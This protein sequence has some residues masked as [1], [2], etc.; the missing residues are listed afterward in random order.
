MQLKGLVRFFAIAL[1][2]ISFYQLH[3]TLVVRNH[4]KKQQEK[5]QAFVNANFSKAET[6]IKDLEFNKR[7]RR[8]LDST[9]E[10]TVTYGITGAITYQKAKEQELNLGLDLQGGM[11]V[12]LEVELEG[13]IKTLANNPK[14][15]SLNNAINAAILEK[16]NSD[17]DFITLFAN[18]Y[19]AQ[20]PNGK[21]ASLFAGTGGRT[22]KI[23]DTDNDVITKLKAS[24]EG[25]ISN[26]FNVLGKRI[27]QFGVAQPNIQL[28]K[29]KGII[30]VELPGVKDDPERVRKYLQATANLQFWE[31]YN[32]GELDKP[33]TDAEKALQAYYATNKVVDTVAAPV[34]AT[35]GTT[36]T[37]KS[38]TIGELVKGGTTAKKDSVTTAAGAQS[39]FKIFQ[40]VPP[41][42]DAQGR[43]SFAPYIGFI[44]GRDTSVFNEYMNLESVKSQ[45]PGNVRFAFG[46]PETNENGV[47]SDVVSIYALK[48]V[49]GS[50][51]AKLE[52]DGVQQ[53]TQDYDDKGRPAIKM[54][55]TKQGERIWGEL[56][57]N[58][59]GKPIAIVLDNIVYSAPNVINPITT[60]NSEISGSFTIEEAQDLSN[61]LQSGKLPAPAKIV[62]EQVVGPTLGASA[63][64]GGALAFAISFGVIFILMLV[65]YNTGGWVANIALILNLLFTIGVLSALGATLTAPGIAGLVLTI[66]MAVDTNVI[67][68][69]RIKE[70]LT[71]GKSY[72]MA[73]SEGYKRSMAPVLDAHITTLLTALILF[74]FGLGP[75]L[76]FA[77]T[78]ILGIILSLFCG[79][80]ISRLITDF[81]TNKKR[82]FNY[83]TATSK[84]VFKHASYKFIEYRKVAY[85]ISVIVLIVG[86]GALFNGFD[87]GVEY[88][89]G[90]SYT[91]KFDK[92]TENEK[93][94]E[95]LKVVFEESPVLKT[96]GDNKTL[97]ITTS[98]MI[99]NVSKSADSVVENK[100]FE[101]LKSSLPAGITY[102]EFKKNYKQSSQ[103]V[104]PSISDDLKKGAVQAT[105]FAILAIILYIFL[106]F[107]DWRY[108][109]G[110]IIALLHDVFVTLAVFSF[111][112]GVVPFPLEIDQHF[113]AAILTVI[114]FSMNDTVIVFDRIREYSS[115]LKGESKSTIIN[116][117]INDTLSRTIMTSLTVFL[118]LLILFIFGGEVTRGFA[119]AMLIGVVTGTYSSIFVAAPVLVDIAKDK[120]LGAA[121]AAGSKKKK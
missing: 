2:L 60:G 21:L 57:T 68:F 3:F 104:Q 26:T 53:A 80:L 108:S 46:I 119:F 5:A 12:T 91:V 121:D 1:I 86:V 115:K 36:D 38:A 82:H 112:K 95:S 40:P 72:Q 13:L 8:L 90:R 78:Q 92:P 120:P 71:L 73:V 35:A 102:A 111:L 109:L 7:L 43:M 74:Y 15:Q 18:A 85:F 39:F 4:E 118:T 30:T 83:F 14:D 99:D 67:I 55:M 77:T 48:T 76:G 41:Q 20:N 44:S 61:I 42:Q 17:A 94:R 98:F 64:E 88:K 117:A 79:I 101:G 81:W 29:T 31:L 100:L 93:I 34:A 11:S 97:N 66:G 37:T 113:I 52:G 87:Q 110:T 106:R 32:I 27:D 65:Y 10:T 28:D 116:R 47:K 96:V 16:S 59:V 50:D 49:E 51:R 24:A 62:Q 58:N 22:V 23:E 56:T 105:I 45:F 89:G 84:R 70:E 33:F 54:L 69:E 103:T 25:A 107:R 63:I 19:K 9:K 75:V 6:E 114:G